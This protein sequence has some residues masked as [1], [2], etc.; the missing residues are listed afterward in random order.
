MTKNQIKTATL[1][2]HWS[3]CVYP[4]DGGFYEMSSLCIRAINNHGAVIAE[5]DPYSIDALVSDLQREGWKIV[6]QA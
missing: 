5:I 3:T 4:I 6:R 2:E 1:L